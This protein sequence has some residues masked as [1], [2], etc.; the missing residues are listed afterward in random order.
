MKAN[1]KQNAVKVTASKISTH[2]MVQVVT[3][4]GK[5]CLH[6]VVTMI[7]LKIAAQ[8]KM[9]AEAESHCET[10]A[11]GNSGRIPFDQKQL[12]EF[13]EIFGD[14]WNSFFP[15]IPERGRTREEYP[16]LRIFLNRNFYGSC[17]NLIFLLKFL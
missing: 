3:K 9:M 10:E 17:L 14:E 7:C 16:N 12:F 13:P 1:R 5:Q 8:A 4:Y 15:E 11:T 2:V 6:Q